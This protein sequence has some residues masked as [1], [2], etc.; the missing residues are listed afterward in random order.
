VVRRYLQ[1]AATTREA[2]T[3]L[4]PMRRPIRPL[5]ALALGVLLALTA[6]ACRN[7]GR[8]LRDPTSPLPPTTTVAPTTL[9]PGAIVAPTTPPAVLTLLTPWQ[10]GAAVPTRYT[11]DDAD[12][13]PALT[14]TNLPP[15]T[16]EV[17]ITMTD[18][19]AGFT[20]WAMAGIGLDRT[21]LIE[22]EIPDGAIVYAN[23]FGDLGWAGPCPP[24][25][26]AAHTYLFTVHAL[27]QQLEVA[28]EATAAE[29][30]D[31]LNQTALAQS[32][33]SGTYAR[34]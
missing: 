28:D 24:P 19:D 5:P 7:D 33:V 32:S 6:A 11:C 23:D 16:V 9:V 10:N 26:D 15:G 30:V 27:N 17:A 20:H 2:V 14:W 34:A 22:G 3:R 13:S 1:V 25:G 31:A 12:L 21:G 4:P 29:V 8:D 18:L